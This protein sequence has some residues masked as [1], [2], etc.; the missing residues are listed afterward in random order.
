M[1]RTL[2]KLDNE[3][4]KLHTKNGYILNTPNTE[5][6]SVRIRKLNYRAEK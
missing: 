2:S 1:M 6:I 3:I 4:N 5:F